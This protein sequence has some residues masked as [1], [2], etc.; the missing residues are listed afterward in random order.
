MNKEEKKFKLSSEE[1]KPILTLGKSCIASDMITVDGLPVGYM[2]REEPEFEFDSGW[3]F[4]SG[5]EDQSYADN[6]DNM[7]IYDLNT[8]VNYDPSIIKLLDQ[9]IGSE[10]ERDATGNFRSVSG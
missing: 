5:K 4:F 1:I 3:R 8:I 6:P 9:K 2:Y 10:Y 7:M